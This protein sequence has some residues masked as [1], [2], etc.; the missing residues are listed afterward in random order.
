MRALFCAQQCDEEDPTQLNSLTRPINNAR[1]AYTTQLKSA[2]LSAHPPCSVSSDWRVARVSLFATVCMRAQ[3]C[4]RCNG[5]A[6]FD[7]HIQLGACYAPTVE[8][9]HTVLTR[10]LDERGR[11]AA[12][13]P[14]ACRTRHC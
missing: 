2:Y 5:R 8:R 11:G 10:A 6:V 4:R 13:L 1:F 3:V 7:S 9:V 14:A 12:R